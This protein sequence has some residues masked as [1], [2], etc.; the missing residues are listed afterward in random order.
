[1]LFSLSM[2]SMATGWSPSNAVFRMRFC[3]SLSFIGF[4]YE[5]LNFNTS[6]NLSSTRSLTNIWNSMLMISL[7]VAE[8]YKP[9]S[10][11]LQVVFNSIINNLLFNSSVKHDKTLGI[12]IIMQIANYKLEFRVNSI[13]YSL[14]YYCSLFYYITAVKLSRDGHDNTYKL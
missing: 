8:T 5:V 10:G 7:Y 11:L 3:I 12:D 14:H 4:L 1:M 2:Y 6:F 9:L 13:T